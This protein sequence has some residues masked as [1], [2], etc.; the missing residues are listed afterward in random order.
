MHPNPKREVA[1]ASTARPMSSGTTNAILSAIELMDQRI[2]GLSDRVDRS[3]K[4][5]S[6]SRPSEEP[7]RG[8]STIRRVVDESWGTR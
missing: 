7:A 6:S 2:S 1:V 4:T 3:D 5:A 8:R